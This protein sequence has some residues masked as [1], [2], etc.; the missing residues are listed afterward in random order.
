MPCNVSHAEGSTLLVSP[1]LV[2]NCSGGVPAVSG[3]KTAPLS[4]KIDLYTADRT[5]LTIWSEG[6]VH[7]WPRSA[8][9]TGR[10]PLVCRLIRVPARGP[11]QHDVWL[12]TDVLDPARLSAATAAKFYRWRWRNE[13]LFRIY[14]RTINKMKLSSRTV[15]LVHREAFVSLRAVQ[16]LLAHAEWALGSPSPTV[17]P[18]ISPRQVLIAIR[19]ELNGTASRREGSYRKRLEGCRAEARLQKSPKSRR[20]WPRR[21]EHKPPGPPVLHTLTEEQKALLQQHFDATQ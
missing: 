12:L 9:E 21:K 11:A 8:Q 17:A 5:P 16:L 14:K 2:A 18:A 19:Q 6:L 1:C 10:P 3:V 4:S 7:C 15:R 13:G 20:A